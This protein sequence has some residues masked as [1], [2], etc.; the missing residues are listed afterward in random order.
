VYDDK[1][2]CI[3]HS[4]DPEKA[5]EKFREVLD[6]VVREKN[7]DF[8]GWVF[9]CDAVLPIRYF[10]GPVR[11]GFATFRAGYG[12]M[13][14]AV[15]QSVTFHGLADFESATFEGVVSFSGAKF[16]GEA[17]FELATFQDWA[18]FFGATFEREA[19]FGCATFVGTAGFGGAT[20]QGEA[21]FGGA[22]FQGAGRFGEAM[23]QGEADFGRATFQG[24]ARFVGQGDNRVFSDSH[25]TDFTEGRFEQP[26]K[27]QLRHV[28][29]GR[30]LFVGADV[31][32][33][34]FTDVEWARRPF[35]G[36]RW[37]RLVIRDDRLGR[38]VKWVCTRWPRWLKPRGRPAVWD[39]LAPEEKHQGK[40][41]ALIGK[42]YRQLKHNYEEQRDPITA[43]DFHFGEMHMRR[44]SKPPTIWFLRFLKRNFSLLALYRWVSGYG[45]DY[46]LPLVWIGVVLVLWAGLFAWLKLDVASASPGG[47]G[48]QGFWDY[49]F[50]S[51]TCFV[52]WPEKGFQPVSAVARYLSLAEG[53]IGPVLIAM[54][55]LALNRR[56]KR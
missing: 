50:Y 37:E 40:D 30:A 52:H 35:W 45:E 33:V 6:E 15:L 51:A 29:L 17:R 49:L 7:Y 26:K 8:R 41:H 14:P 48:P 46:I 42:L 9:P 23:F 18:G 32:E 13:S 24:E 22:T 44:M 25:D 39:E 11:L 2:M 36:R 1:G 31:R 55:T 21:D 53:V 56:F 47:V 54:F 34:D 5:S 43:G 4:A 19:G 27:V 3:C 38:A 10:D 20:F 16:Q 12:S 28:Y